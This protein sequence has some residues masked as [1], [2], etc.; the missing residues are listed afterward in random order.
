MARKP[1]IHFAGALYHVILRGNDR[2]DIFYQPSDRRLWES[3][4]RASMERYRSSIHCFC[5]MTNHLHMVI[6]VDE[7]PLAAT[8]RHAAGQYSRKVNLLQR[9]SGHLFERR[10]RA[11]IV[12]D[13][14]YLKGL[15]RYIHHNPVR[16]GMVAHPGEYRWSSHAIYSGEKTSDWVSLNTVLRAFGPTPRKARTAYIRFMAQ[17][18]EEQQSLFRYPV[19]QD[20]TTFDS[21][22][23]TPVHERRP[24]NFSRTNTLEA[25]V[26]KYIKD[27]LVTDSQLVGPSKQREL[28]RLRYAIAAEA[29]EE[30]A[31]TVAEIARR[32]HRSEAAISQLISRHSA[33]GRRKC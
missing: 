21:D 18:G 13:D 20:T 29:L 27:T 6:R 8:I 16:A 10:H 28:S 25:I 30:G 33:A 2:Q 23:N 17:S 26:Q 31:T 3:I 11:I 1:R 19:T 4:L 15:V 32:L 12:R 24:T 9:R 22:P 7:K 14:A 5:W